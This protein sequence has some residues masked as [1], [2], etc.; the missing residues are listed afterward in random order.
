MFT[1]EYIDIGITGLIAKMPGDIGCFDQ[2]DQRVSGLIALTEMND[3][4]WAIR[5]HVNFF[6]QVYGEVVDGWL[7]GD[8]MGR[9]LE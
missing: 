3:L 8:N 1:G 7:T 6:Y 9:T 2:L 4:W 5:F